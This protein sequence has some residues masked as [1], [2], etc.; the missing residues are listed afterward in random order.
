MTESNATVSHVWKR[1]E[2]WVSTVLQ[3]SSQYNDS[4][5]SANQIIGPPKVFPRHGDIVGAWAQG[6]RAVDE[7]VIVG[8]GR[9]VHPDQIDI[10]ETY[11]PGA[12]VRVSARNSRDK[13]DWEIVWQ[14]EAPHVEG[15]SRIFSLPCSN[16]SCGT[17]DQ[18][19]LDINCSAAG[20]WCEIDCIKLIGYTSHNDMSYK[21]L[22][23]NLKQL[24]ID[25]CLADVTFE[26]DN[27]R[28]ISSYRNILSNRC[29]YFAQLFD[30]YPSDIEKPIKINN[31]SY[32]AFYQILYFIYTDTLE[33]VL[34]YET[35]LELMRK[36]DEYYLSPIYDQA[37]E[38]LKKIINKTNVLKLYVQSGLFSTS[39][40]LN[41]PDNIILND[42]INLCVEFIQK[43]RRDVYFNDQ[44]EQLTKDM[45]LRLIQLVL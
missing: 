21:E 4:T 12:I 30:E 43:N 3:F 31:I 23:A 29:V 24:L 26:L 39:S 35:C 33:P 44:M 42:V 10:Y 18:I 32:E 27:G 11:N 34:Q 8:F 9:P 7:F 37:F 28:T 45:L 6:N 40:D 1:E 17:I 36:A 20:N 2:Q 19:R 25:D 16:L 14:T 13:D 38:S 15:Q 22:T 41:Q 5:W